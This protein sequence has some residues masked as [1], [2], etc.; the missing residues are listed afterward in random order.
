[1]TSEAGDAHNFRESGVQVHVQGVLNVLK[2]LGIL[3]GKPLF[4]RGDQRIFHKGST[5][6][7][8][9]KPGVFTPNFG[10]ADTFKR[11]DIVGTV[12]S[13]FGEVMEEVP[14]PV[15]GFVWTLLAKRSVD[16]GDIVYRVLNL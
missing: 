13:V 1:M 10:P 8:V 16:A 6:I 11:G 3:E 15:N 7:Q 2:T 5:Y 4:P 9:T 12:R 14:S